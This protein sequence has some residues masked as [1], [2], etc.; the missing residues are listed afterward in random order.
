MKTHSSDTASTMIALILVP[1]QD[2]PQPIIHESTA[3]FH[4]EIR[5]PNLGISCSLARPP[6]AMDVTPSDRGLHSF[7]QTD[8]PHTAG[9][10]SSQDIPFLHAASAYQ[11]NL[12]LMC[13]LLF[14]SQR[15]FR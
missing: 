2:K 12:S 13:P 9:A 7:L 4:T 6:F 3:D 11:T 15:L 5:W 10:T 1:F 14:L 8:L